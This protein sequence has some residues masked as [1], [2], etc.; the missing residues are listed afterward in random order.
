MRQEHLHINKPVL[1]LRSVSVALLL[2]LPLSLQDIKISTANQAVLTGEVGVERR[3]LGMREA[4]GIGLDPE[5]HRLEQVIDR[6]RFP[7][8]SQQVPGQSSVGA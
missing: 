7:Q 8:A 2:L 5:S 3:L 6:P 1:R 4:R